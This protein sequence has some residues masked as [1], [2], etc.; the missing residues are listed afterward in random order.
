MAID[1]TKHV[2]FMADNMLDRATALTAS[3]EV[4]SLPVTNL[5]NHQRTELFRTDGNVAG[6]VDI[7]ITLNASEGSVGGLA[8]VDHNLSLAGSIRIQA[9][10][11]AHDGAAQ[12]VDEIIQPYAPIYAF[13]D[14]V[15]GEG[16][17]GGYASLGPFSSYSPRSYLRVISFL[18]LVAV[19]DADYWRVTLI[20]STLDY[21]QCGRLFIGEVWQPETNYSW[22]S[23]LSRKP[24]SKKRRSRGG[25]DYG[26]PKPGR[27]ALEFNLDWLQLNDQQRL[28]AAY[29]YVESDT[30]VIVIQKPDTDSFD[31]ELRSL[32]CTFDGLS[33]EAAFEGNHRSS[34][35]LIEAL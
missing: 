31:R 20:D 12:V 28:W 22:S 8:V 15:F 27:M 1:K 11:D 3:S 10:T 29:L 25:Q 30:P 23:K 24:E 33:V 2:I 5:Q 26:N 7:D 13:G 14:G 4:A 35:K 21:I 9:W 6:Q 17:F 16:L 34:I 19:I 18:Q 32:Y